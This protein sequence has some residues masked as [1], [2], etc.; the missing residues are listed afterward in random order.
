MSS[1]NIL[2][3]GYIGLP[4][5]A[6]LCSAGHKV[7]GVD[8][9]K[10]LIKDLGNGLIHIN[11]PDLDD[12]VKDSLKS[13]RL[14]LSNKPICAD[15][16]FITVPTPILNMGQKSLKA[17]LSNVINA[18]KAISEILKKNDLIILESTCPVETT[19]KITEIVSKESE[20]LKKISISPTVLKEFFQGTSLMR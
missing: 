8:I 16:H 9:N 17:D 4:T 2:G 14:S 19:I 1:C 13:N 5:A 3:L 18:A 11:E 12:L 15:I 6:I 20:F 10:N 7:N